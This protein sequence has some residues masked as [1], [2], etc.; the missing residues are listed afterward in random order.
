[1][2]RL[3]TQER[4]LRRLDLVVPAGYEL[5]FLDLWVNRSLWAIDHSVY[6]DKYFMECLAKTRIVVE[7]EGVLYDKQYA[8]QQGWDVLALPGSELFE[9]LPLDQP[10]LWE[11]DVD[12][13]TGVPQLLAIDDVSV[14]ANG[15]KVNNAPAHTHR[16]TRHVDDIPCGCWQCTSPYCWNWPYYKHRRWGIT[17][18]SLVD[19]HESE[20]LEW[21]ASFFICD[22][23]SP[24][25]SYEKLIPS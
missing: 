18:I 22:Y 4:S 8:L 20:M 17:Y 12:Y 25:E 21:L 11:S 9:G 7:A 14:Y 15:G 2:W 5:G 1:M 24:V 6:V 23:T 10:K 3:W 16:L 19:V 13:L